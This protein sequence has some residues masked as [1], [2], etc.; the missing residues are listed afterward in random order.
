MRRFSSWLKETVFQKIVAKAVLTQPSEHGVVGGG[1]SVS[2][3]QLHLHQFGSRGIHIH[4]PHLH[5]Q[6]G[7]LSL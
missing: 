2:P 6:N 7:Q 5:N 4:L 1:S 3:S